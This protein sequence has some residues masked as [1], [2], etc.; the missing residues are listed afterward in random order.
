MP[1]RFLAVVWLAGLLAA[2]GCGGGP[3]LA[4]VQGTV[5]VN[6]KAVDKIMVEFHPEGNG[7]RSIGETDKDGRYTL[8]S[9]DGKRKGALV[10]RH[11]VVLRDTGILGDE[12]L[13]RAGESV[14][15]SKGKKPRIAARFSDSRTTTIIKDVN[16]GSNNI[17]LE[18][19][20]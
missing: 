5:K 1:R 19:T 9:D 4:E 20:P 13:G 10:G 6:G 12:F 14:D 16:A 15:M 3:R 17:D 18:A 8:M 11:R 2:V 7:P